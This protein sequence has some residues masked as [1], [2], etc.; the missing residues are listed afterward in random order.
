MNIT[1]SYLLLFSPTG[2][3]RKVATAVADGCRCV[4]RLLDATYTT[5]SELS[6]NNQSLLFL[7]LPVY[8]GHLP[9]LALQRLDKMHGDNT[10]I[11][12]IALYGNRAYEKA[13]DEMAAFVSERG[14]VPI[15]AAAFVGEHSYSTAQTPIAMGRPDRLDLD[16]AR[17]WGRDVRDKID[18]CDMWLPIDV[19]RMRAP[20]D[21]PLS[22]WRFKA[23]IAGL[24]RKSEGQPKLTPQ[25]DTNLC[26]ACGKCARVCP[27]GAIKRNDLHH[28]DANLC[29]KCCACVKFCPKQARKLATPYAPV[30]S[31]CFAQRKPPVT[32]L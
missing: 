9:K 17:A 25:V 12:L 14:F 22:V 28:V 8:G 32:I 11:V 16:F 19:N 15:A 23:F 18:R 21:S 20:H 26:N 30:L 3:S 4:P 6:F 29:I 13:L 5:P 24:R 7:A 31:Q 10:P 27:S 1:S 2:T